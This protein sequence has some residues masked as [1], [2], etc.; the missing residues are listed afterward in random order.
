LGPGL[1][2][3]EIYAVNNKPTPHTPNKSELFSHER[4]DSYQVAVE[5]LDVADSLARRLPKIKG[6]LGVQIARAS[7]GIVLR[8]AEGA[9]AEY[10]S[11]DQKRYFRSAL[12]SA[13]ECAAV[14]DICRVRRV[15]PPSKSQE[16][17]LCLFGWYKCSAT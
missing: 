15:A 7:E 8:I 16:V 14:L 12:C 5:F 3:E 17:A 6:P 2:E 4:L 9:D 10:T 11:V 13:T 1:K